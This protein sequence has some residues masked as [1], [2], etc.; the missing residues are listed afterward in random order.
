MLSSC[1]IHLLLQ[2]VEEEELQKY[3]GDLTGP[4]SG[5]IFLYEAADFD[6]STL[7]SSMTTHT[8]STQI[9]TYTSGDVD[10][11]NSSI[12]SSRP[13]KAPGTASHYQADVGGSG[14][15]SLASIDAAMDDDATGHGGSKQKEKRKMSFFL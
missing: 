10:A 9:P 1:L 11:L 2:P 7:V 8:I 12:G 4:G 3:F 13:H 6:A 5:Y 15:T 14:N